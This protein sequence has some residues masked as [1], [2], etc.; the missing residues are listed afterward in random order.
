MPWIYGSSM[1]EAF[2]RMAADFEIEIPPY[3]EKEPSGPHAIIET[4]G[5]ITFP[6]AEA[7]EPTWE[8]ILPEAAWEVPGKA[9]SWDWIAATG[10]LVL[11]LVVCLLTK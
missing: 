2:R 8:Q 6:K 11:S 5:I 3:E 7:R 10:S 1:E 9:I 4:K